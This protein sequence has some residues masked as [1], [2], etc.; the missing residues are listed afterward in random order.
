MSDYLSGIFLLITITIAFSFMVIILLMTLLRRINRHTVISMIWFVGAMLSIWVADRFIVGAF[1]LPWE[2][3]KREI[4][5]EALL[6]NEADLPDDWVITQNFDY[7]YAERAS[8][9]YRERTFYSDLKSL[10]KYFFQEIYQYRSVR[11]AS[12]QYNALKFDLPK[13]H[14]YRGEAITRQVEFQDSHATKYIMECLYSSENDCFYI[15]QYE[16]YILVIEMP[17]ANSSVPLDDFIEIAQLADE[18]FSKTLQ[19]SRGSSP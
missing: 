4:T 6:L 1:C 19:R 8:S 13:Q 2:C 5:P 14:S 7:A 10:N 12:F 15:A 11:G 18:K 16:E 3:V 9:A 17:P